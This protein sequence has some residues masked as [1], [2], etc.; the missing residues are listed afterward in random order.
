M[1]RVYVAIIFLHEI[2]LYSIKIF[3]FYSINFI[4]YSFDTSV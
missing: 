2:L 1:N 4:Q 3:L